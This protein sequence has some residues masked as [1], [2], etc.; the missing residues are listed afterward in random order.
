MHGK[1]PWSGWITDTAESFAHAAVGLYNNVADWRQ[2]QENGANIIN[3]FYERTILDKR[4]SDKIDALQKDLI[5][6]RE[7][8]FIGSLLRH[9][10]LN[11]TKYMAK[12]IEEKNRK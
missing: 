9:Q 1:L 6:H 8:N 5:K 2:S 11:S 7:Q 3:A 4:F 12:W 10:T